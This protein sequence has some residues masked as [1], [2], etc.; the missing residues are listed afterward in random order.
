MYSVD[1]KVLCHFYHCLHVHSN[2]H[3]CHITLPDMHYAISVPC[4]CPHWYYIENCRKSQIRRLRTPNSALQALSSKC[5]QEGSMA[6]WMLDKV[7]MKYI[8]PFAKYIYLEACHCLSALQ[9]WQSRS[10]MLTN[11]DWHH[12]QHS[13]V[14]S[15][16][17]LQRRRAAAAAASHSFI[18]NKF[19]TLCGVTNMD[20]ALPIVC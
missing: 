2:D 14:V 19:T 10:G 5:G 15:Q 6:L 18:Y 7:Y 20:L 4:S 16:F 11:K 3:V 17:S 12:V 13:T 8:K 9:H 1:H